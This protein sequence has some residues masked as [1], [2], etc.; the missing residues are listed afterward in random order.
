MTQPRDT[1]DVINTRGTAATLDVNANGDVW[2]AS[3]VEYGTNANGE[4]WKY[5]DGLLICTR[6][7]TPSVTGMTTFSLA[8]T[9]INT[10]R[11]VGS[12]I[13]STSDAILNVK[14]SNISTTTFQC[15]VAGITQGGSGLGFLA[16]LIDVLAIGKW[17]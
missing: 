14:L 16:Q 6:S 17:K 10:P 7:V 9:F 12:T 5:P 13:S 2:G 8:S 4:Y 1:A 15:A 11:I 3:N